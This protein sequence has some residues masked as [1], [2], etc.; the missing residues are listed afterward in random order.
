MGSGSLVG[1]AIDEADRWTG[2]GARLAFFARSGTHVCPDSD[3][4]L[5]LCAIG[6]NRGSCIAM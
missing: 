5:A 1:G 2:P 4:P 6:G 3:V